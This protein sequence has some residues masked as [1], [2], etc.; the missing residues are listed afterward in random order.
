MSLT[1]MAIIAAY[2][3]DIRMSRYLIVQYLP[4]YSEIEC[5]NEKVREYTTVLIQILRILIQAPLVRA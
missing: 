3:L 5:T 4:D 2:Y 1:A